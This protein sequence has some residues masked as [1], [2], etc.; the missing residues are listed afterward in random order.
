MAKIV[1]VDDDED[2]IMLI[3]LVL[4][5]MGHEV[6]TAANGLIGLDVCLRERPDLAIVDINMPV[7]TGLDMLKIL[8]GSDELCDL[9]V[10]L[11]TAMSLDDDIEA[12][13]RAGANDYVTKPFRPT[14]LV[15]RVAALL[16]T[17]QEMTG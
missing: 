5:K 10:I 2:M 17:H 8:R 4:A 14:G 7:M 15:E 6:H 13:R 16:P 9:P 11:V 1:V 12:G 3:E